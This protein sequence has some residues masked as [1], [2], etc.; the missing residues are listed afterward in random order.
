MI[1]VIIYGKK[2]SEKSTFKEPIS[3]TDLYKK[4]GLDISEQNYINSLI[5]PAE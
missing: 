4:Y 5:R 2:V 1:L 3:D